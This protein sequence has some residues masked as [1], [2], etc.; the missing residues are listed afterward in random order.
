MRFAGAVLIVATL[1]CAALDA[2]ADDADGARREFTE[3]VRLLQ[4]G[5][6]V[7]ARRMFKSADAKH[8]APAIVYNLG[9]AEE[10]LGHAQA[11][12]D[13]YEAYV[14]E[15]GDGGELSATAAVA[16]AQIKARS[17]R[18]RIGTA[19]TGARLFVDGVALS[20]PSPTIHLVAA[21]HHVVVAEA[22]TWR[23]EQIIEAP[24]TG[25][26]LE[27]IILP[28]TSSAAPVTATLAAGGHAP[29]EADGAPGAPRSEG[30]D[31]LVWGASFALVPFH[32]LG[33]PNKDRGNGLGASQMAAGGIVEIGYAL[34]ERFELLARSLIAF[35]PDAK[36][37]TLHMS[38]IGFS[39]RV[40]APLW[41]GATFI[42]GQLATRAKDA[43]Y[44][45]NLVFGTIVEA[46]Y[47]VIPTRV[48]QWS[49]GFQPG[50]LLATE[51]YEN[52]A[53]VFPVTFG[54]RAY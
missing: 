41:L 42:G 18:L 2:R 54:F 19:P 32:L 26:V 33:A 11:A 52:A 22:L 24:G 53:F 40:A 17:T 27:L 29:V 48:G 43:D 37:T 25:D 45:T 38:G 8:H 50:L 30:P 51:A 5:D 28:A 10:R 9:L 16:I 20:E 3:G 4:I 34:T 12:V 15:A 14:S 39:L 7:G 44:Q 23:G 6:F 46:T 36:P 49:V 35:G 21:G 47:A 13:A 1:L 31:G